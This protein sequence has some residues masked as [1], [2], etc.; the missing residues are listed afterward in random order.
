MCQNL[1][2][3][4]GVRSNLISKANHM[5]INYKHLLIYF[6]GENYEFSGTV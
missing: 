6:L 5:Q 2:L 4:S 1:V 3:Q